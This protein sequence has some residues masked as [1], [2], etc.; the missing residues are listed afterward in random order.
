[1]VKP[2]RTD[3]VE[4]GEWSASKVKPGLSEQKQSP[5]HSLPPLKKLYFSLH[6]FPESHAPFCILIL[7][8][9]P[10]ANISNFLGSPIPLNIQDS[11]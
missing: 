10:W 2:H 11:Q 7:A 6:T 9:G 1:M 4:A 8:T 5:S 3:L